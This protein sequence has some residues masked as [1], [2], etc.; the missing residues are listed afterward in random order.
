[1]PA[2]ACG[3]KAVLTSL[4]CLLLVLL[5]CMVHVSLQISFFWMYA[6]EWDC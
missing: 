4:S 6:Q 5:G 1:M 2:T 3:I